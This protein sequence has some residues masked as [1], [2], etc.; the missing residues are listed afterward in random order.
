MKK[1]F[2]LFRHGQTDM[3]LARRWQGR[4]IDAPLNPTGIRQAEALADTLLPL[5][6]QAV[7]S[8]PLLRAVQTAKIAAAKTGAPVFVDGGLIEGCF[9]EAE[10]KTLQEIHALF[11]ELA[12]RWENLDDDTLDTRFPNG[13]SKREIQTRILQAMTRIAEMQPYERI[14]IS[15]HS[16]AIRCTMLAFGQKYPQVPHGV[17]FRLEWDGKSFSGEQQ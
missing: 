6:I 14:G 11:P 3:N 5:R 9:G 15:C 10:G 8:S 2:Y 17:P 12:A 7:F 16:A 4:L 13:E 1:S